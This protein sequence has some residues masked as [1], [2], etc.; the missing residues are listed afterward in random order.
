MFR[1]RNYHLVSDVAVSMGMSVA[2]FII[3]NG[4]LSI[5]DVPSGT[6]GHG[7][8]DDVAPETEQSRVSLVQLDD[9]LRQM[10][11]ISVETVTNCDTVAREG[12]EIIGSGDAQTFPRMVKIAEISDASKPSVNDIPGCETPACPPNALL[13]QIQPSE[14]SQPP[15]NGSKSIKRSKSRN[16]EDSADSNGATAT[17]C[18]GNPDNAISESSVSGKIERSA[19]KPGC[20]TGKRCHNSLPNGAKTKPT[21]SCLPSQG[22][23]ATSSTPLALLSELSFSPYNSSMREVAHKLKAMTLIEMGDEPS[24]KIKVDKVRADGQVHILSYGVL[25]CKTSSTDPGKSPKR[26]PESKRVIVEPARFQYS[27]PSAPPTIDAQTPVPACEVIMQKDNVLEREEHSETRA[28]MEKPVSVRP[29]SPDPEQVTAP[30][31]PKDGAKAG[32]KGE[33][34]GERRLVHGKYSQSRDT[35]SRPEGQQTEGGDPALPVLDKLDMD[36]TSSDATEEGSGS[37]DREMPKL[38]LFA[39]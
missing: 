8:F 26:K 24:G 17:K 6:L 2:D 22:G 19:V 25:A 13:N 11:D 28:A 38:T 4:D 36:E 12:N 5:V 32:G 3:L 7:G 1:P 21:E 33:E 27:P 31:P 14:R 37:D 15:T 16:N 35:D 39:Y 18:E 23:H 9:V 34:K 10:L 29:S 20:F 30:V